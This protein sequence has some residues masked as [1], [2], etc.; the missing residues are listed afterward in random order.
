MNRIKADLVNVGKSYIISADNNEMTELSLST[1]QLLA[2][3]QMDAN[4]LLE[5]AKNEAAQILNNAKQ[6]A[7]NDAQNSAEEIKNQAYQEGFKN[8]HDEGYQ[9]G[10]KQIEDELSIKIQNFEN[11]LNSQF[12]IKKRIIKSAHLDI[13]ELVSLISEKIC[14]KSFENDKE[15]LKNLVEQAIDALKDKEFVTLI[16]NPAM[17]S[18]ISEISEKLKNQIISLEHLKILEDINVSADGVIAESIDTRV[19]STI[20]SQ[21]DEIQRLLKEKLNSTP[22]VKMVEE[23]EKTKNDDDIA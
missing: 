8:G 2:K 16:V 5:N 20:S 4:N 15:I 18:E 14:H 10:K 13:V 11:F 12:D 3:A 21:I 9:E 6:N 19:D 7:V 1:Q 23:V 22:E 17:I